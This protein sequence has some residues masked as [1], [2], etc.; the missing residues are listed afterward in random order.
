[1]LTEKQA[2]A[3]SLSFKINKYKKIYLVY[4]SVDGETSLHATGGE[5]MTNLFYLGK[6]FMFRCSGEFKDRPRTHINEMNFA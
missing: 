5:F 1:M 3:V 6:L 4:Y 2:T